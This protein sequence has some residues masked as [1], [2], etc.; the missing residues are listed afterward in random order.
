MQFARSDRASEGVS[1]RRGTMMAITLAASLLGTLS[2]TASAFASAKPAART[3]KKVSP[4][5][6][7]FSQLT[8]AEQGATAG[9]TVTEAGSTLFEPLFAVWGDDHPL[10]LTIDSAGGGSGGGKTDAEDNTIQIGASDAPRFTTDPS[11][12]VNIP[13][14]VSA[15]EII[16]NVPGLSKSTHLKLNPTILNGMYTGAIDN[17]DNAAIKS[18][19]P[20]V[21]LP[22]QAIVPIHRTGSTGD[23]YLFSS[24]LYLG[25]TDA[26]VASTG[27][28]ESPT[29]PNVASALA[30]GSN[31]TVESACEET[32][33]CIAYLG[34]SYLRSAEASSSLGTAMLLNG[35]G[36]YVNINVT[37]I[38]N[39]VADVPRIPASGS[40]SLVYEKHAKFGWPIVNFEY[41]FVN[42]SPGVSHPADV[43]ALLAWAMD[44]RKGATVAN[45]S[46]F[47][48]QPL[49]PKAIGVALALLKSIPS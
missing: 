44:P 6:S 8:A 29:W 25:D 9:D 41:A 4:Y 5:H 21:T 39:E 18:L 47:F 16:Y 20:G 48:F 3:P 10:G 43:K 17:W 12:F 28:S 30:E 11:T 49:P 34:S 36:N 42:T 27:P 13:V 46:P 40:V 33:G 24:Y 31:G 14:V 32:A 26:F 7:Y 22:N 2:F 19:N 35:A 37:N 45:L 15:Q 23:S 1:R 38:K